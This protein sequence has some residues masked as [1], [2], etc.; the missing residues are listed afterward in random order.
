MEPLKSTYNSRNNYLIL[1]FRFVLIDLWLILEKFAGLSKVEYFQLTYK[2]VVIKIGLTLKI[3]VNLDNCYKY[4][5]FSYF[6]HL[7][8]FIN[9]E[10]Y[11]VKLLPEEITREFIHDCTLQLGWANIFQTSNAVWR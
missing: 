1:F 2:Y 7:H 3:S 11:S 5:V 10:L 4:I 6:K 8:L 9:L